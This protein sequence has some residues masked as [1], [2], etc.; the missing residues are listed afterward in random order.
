MKWDEPYNS[1][2]IR[3]LGLCIFI[4]C[5]IHMWIYIL[6]PYSRNEVFLNVI[7]EHKVK[8]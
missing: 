7:Q 3:S 6:S 4:C 8:V 1:E 2:R 5:I